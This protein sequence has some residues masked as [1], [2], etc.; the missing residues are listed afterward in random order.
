MNLTSQRGRS[1]SVQITRGELW[2]KR[3]ESIQL[4]KKLQKLGIQLMPPLFCLMLNTK[5]TFK[6]KDSK[7]Q[8]CNFKGKMYIFTDRMH[9]F[10]LKAVALLFWL[11]LL[12]HF[13]ADTVLLIKRLKTGCWTVFQVILIQRVEGFFQWWHYK[14]LSRFFSMWK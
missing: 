6:K 14:V 9:S 1:A 12:K 4:K 11:I 8:K 2:E 10:A 5:H 7:T 13:A 3:V